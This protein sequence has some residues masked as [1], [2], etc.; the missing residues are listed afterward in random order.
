M[1]DVFKN[2]I[3]KGSDPFKQ[4]I[5]GVEKNLLNFKHLPITACIV[6]FNLYQL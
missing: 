1:N 3:Y 5:L 6:T 2:R 4:R